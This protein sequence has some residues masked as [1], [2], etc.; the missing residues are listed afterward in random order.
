M[1]TRVLGGVGVVLLPLHHGSVGV[2]I[3]FILHGV[4]AQGYQC[5]Y[6]ADR[7]VYPL[8]LLPLSGTEVICI[9]ASCN[10]LEL[11]PNCG[12]VMHMHTIAT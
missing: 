11:Q 8:S 4:L 10:A 5:V 6:G 1:Y 7:H 2:A 3:W 12:V 9:L